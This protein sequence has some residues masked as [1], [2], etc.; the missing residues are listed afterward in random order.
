M[1]LQ[2]AVTSPEA[3]WAGVSAPLPQWLRDL[4]ATVER[5]SQTQ[6]G[7]GGTGKKGAQGW[8][9][10]RKQGSCGHLLCSEEKPLYI[11]KE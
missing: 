5:K 4:G 10:G 6:K 7:H 1:K 8:F 3:G 9:R 11:G 2:P